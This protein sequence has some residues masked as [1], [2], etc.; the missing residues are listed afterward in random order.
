MIKYIA[1]EVARCA[2]VDA[3]HNC[4]ALLGDISTSFSASLTD[5]ARL[6][7]IL[8]ESYP[9]ACGANASLSN[10]NAPIVGPSRQ[11]KAT[12]WQGSADVIW[13]S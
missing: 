3:D 10:E 9:Q 5:F 12:R 8:A 13:K 1:I 11:K 7:A 2:K 4:Q 6:A